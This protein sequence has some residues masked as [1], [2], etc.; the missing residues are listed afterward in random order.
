MKIEQKPVMII[1]F[2]FMTLIIFFQLATDENQPIEH[3]STVMFDHYC[4]Q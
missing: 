2:Q 3:S 4:N 1:D